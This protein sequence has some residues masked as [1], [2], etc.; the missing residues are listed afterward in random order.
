M[1]WC[2]YRIK[3]ISSSLLNVCSPCTRALITEVLTFVWPQTL[4]RCQVMNRLTSEGRN[5]KTVF[6][7]FSK[8]RYQLLLLSSIVVLV[9]DV[10]RCRTRLFYQASRYR[11][12]DD[13]TTAG[14]NTLQVSRCLLTCERVK[15]TLISNNYKQNH[16]NNVE[17]RVISS[18]NTY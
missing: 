9:G 12:A 13:K 4:R 15:L 3:A 14:T 7:P 17:K 1:A 6:A 10:I 2:I 18:T 5:C 11:F 16:I 8:S